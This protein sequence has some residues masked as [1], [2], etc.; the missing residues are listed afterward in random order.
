M[1]FQLDKIENLIP[2]ELSEQRKGRLR[3]GLNQF[4]SSN[5]DSKNYTEFYSESNYPYFLQG[6]M[7]RDL[8]FPFWDSSTMDFSKRY[9]DAVIIS[10]TCDLD[11]LNKRQIPKQ[12]VIA[13]L[14]RLEDFEEGLR[15]HQV[16]NPELIL[17]N[18]RNQEYSNIMY[19]PEINGVE[20]LATLDELSSVTLDEIINLK[21]DFD[22][23]RIKSLDLFGHYLFV[24]KFSYHLCRLPE[25]TDR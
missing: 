11:E 18:L 8:R 4:H 1:S 22:Q 13:K 23:N 12:I 7:I 24:F 17:K 25:E 6:D 15:L 19:F 20:Y 21:S 14:I 5:T 10:N 9:Y 2:K 3:D 16:N